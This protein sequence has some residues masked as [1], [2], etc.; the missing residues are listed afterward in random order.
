MATTTT[1]VNATQDYFPYAGVTEPAIEQSAIPRGEV[2]IQG[3]TSVAAAGVGDNQMISMT[4]TLPGSFA[5][6]LMDFSAHVYGVLAT[7]FNF[8]QYQRLWIRSGSSFANS[9]VFFDMGL[10]G[11][12]GQSGANVS[13]V[14]QPI[15]RYKGLVVPEPGQSVQLGMNIYNTT[16][17]DNTY[18]IDLSGRLLQFD[19]AQANYFGVNTPDP[20][21]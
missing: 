19:I 6:V 12:A 15:G 7:T 9:K 1:T 8:P 4:L 16:A 18:G 14:Y 17:N 11:A 3:S 13:A 21:R 10:N 5:Y 20:V 2:R